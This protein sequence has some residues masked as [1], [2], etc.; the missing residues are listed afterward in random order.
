M[1]QR[2]EISYKTILFTV[3]F[4]IFLWILFVVRDVISLLLLSFTVMAGLRPIV[5]KLEELKFPRPF[6]ILLIYI[7]LFGLIGLAMLIVIPPLVVQFQSLLV[8]IQRYLSYAVPFLNITPADITNQIPFLSQNVL[9]ITTGVFSTLFGFFSFFI[10]TFYFLLERHHLKHFLVNFV[11]QEAEKKIAAIFRQ[12]EG[13]LGA[14]VLGQATLAVIIGFATYLGLTLL[15]VEFALSL[16]IIAGLLEIVPIIGP[17][18]SAIPAVLVALTTSPV[19]AVAVVALFFII[20]QIENN[21]VVPMVM[22]R[23]VGLPPLVTIIALMI[24]GKLAGVAGIVLSVPV[25][26]ILQVV[27]RQL[28]LQYENKS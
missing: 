19:L 21:L 16:A 23:A 18:I 1:T 3:F 5:D 9:K 17:I 25:L 7:V 24:G 11:G 20:Q 13:R 6:A 4:L 22:R 8:E 10:F 12:V 14:W 26:V 28:L 2:I 15:G 27:I